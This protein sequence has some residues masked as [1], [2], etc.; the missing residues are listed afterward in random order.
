VE[1]AVF[2]VDEARQQATLDVFRLGPNG[3]QRAHALSLDAP[4]STTSAVFSTA[5]AALAANDVNQ[6]GVEDLLL[7]VTDTDGRLVVHT[8]LRSPDGTFQDHAQPVSQPSGFTHAA[9]ADVDGDA[10]LDLIAVD[11]LQT[12]THVYFG[13]A[14]S[15]FRAGPAMEWGIW[16]DEPTQVLTGDF[17][18]DGDTDI[19]TLHESCYDVYYRNHGDGSFD[20]PTV[21]HTQMDP[22]FQEAVGV[23]TDGKTELMITGATNVV[24]RLTLDAQGFVEREDMLQLPGEHG[25]YFSF[26]DAAAFPAIRVVSADLNGDHLPDYLF[27]D[28]TGVLLNLSASSSVPLR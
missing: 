3:P 1:L 25:G 14:D 24:E 8:L 28:G 20:A 11:F 9:F 6:D 18:H 26:T 2:G 15:T 13:N 17:D 22:T 4:P 16:A 19:R 5:L 7:A 27:A 23:R 21:F 12:L 10:R